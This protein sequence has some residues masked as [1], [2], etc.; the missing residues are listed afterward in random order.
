MRC[1]G[2]IYRILFNLTRGSFMASPN[3]EG[4]AT[5]ILK[6]VL[7]SNPGLFPQIKT[8]EEAKAVGECVTALRAAILAGVIAQS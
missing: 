2:F 4:A 1:R 5:S 8:V 6:M 7:E 3:Q